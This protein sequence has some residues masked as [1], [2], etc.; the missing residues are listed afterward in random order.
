[1]SLPGSRA[2]SGSGRFSGWCSDEL[3]HGRVGQVGKSVWRDAGDSRR[4]GQCR[5]GAAIGVGVIE[6]LDLGGTAVDG[7]VIHRRMT[8]QA[9]DQQQSREQQRQQA[10]S[11]EVQQAANIAGHSVI[12]MVE[13]PFCLGGRVV[14][15][16]PGQGI[17]H[18]LYQSLGCY[19]LRVTQ[20]SRGF[21]FSLIS[22]CCS[23]TKA[24]LIRSKR[25]H[26]A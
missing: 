12:L 17:R 14:Q 22:G 8:G 21:E 7:A 6:H 11:S 9:G 23:I 4:G 1:M 16:D 26:D 25:L 2:T 15:H 10:Y 13:S 24:P 5:T 20:G 18:G 19:N 3:N